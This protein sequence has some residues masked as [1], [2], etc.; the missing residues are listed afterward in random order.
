MTPAPTGYWGRAVRLNSGGKGHL[1]LDV[2]C[3]RAVRVGP[4]RPFRWCRLA[5][6]D[7]GADGVEHDEDEATKMRTFYG[8]IASPD[9]C[10][11]SARE[12]IVNNGLVVLMLAH[13]LLRC[14]VPDG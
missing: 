13:V 5:Y 1:V 14:G 2:A 11:V 3:Q 8:I 4:R 7:V 12:L 9:A 10:E 6:E